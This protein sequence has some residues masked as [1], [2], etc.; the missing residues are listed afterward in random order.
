MCEDIGS[1]M[2]SRALTNANFT[3]QTSLTMAP[4]DTY[5]QILPACIAQPQL[6]V[7]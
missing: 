2:R 6:E 1:K 5:L 3:R 4:C 7:S